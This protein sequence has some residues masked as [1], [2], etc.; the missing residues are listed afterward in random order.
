M[1]VKF[2]SVVAVRTEYGTTGAS[3]S[4][5]RSTIPYR[6]LTTRNSLV[7]GTRTGCHQSLQTDTHGVHTHNRP[8][9]RA[10]QS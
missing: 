7:S 10:D 9:K 8:M 3:T 4:V 1:R 5:I 6:G 2:M